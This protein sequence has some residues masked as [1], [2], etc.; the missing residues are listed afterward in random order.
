[1][2]YETWTYEPG[3]FVRA[4][5]QWELGVGWHVLYCCDDGPIADSL[6]P[7]HVSLALLRREDRVQVFSLAARVIRSLEAG[8]YEQ[9]QRDC[10]AN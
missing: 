7:R 9:A 4:V 6:A 5:I 1:M 10:Q 3:D 2:T 8:V